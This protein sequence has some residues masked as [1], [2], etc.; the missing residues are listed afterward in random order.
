M[1]NSVWIA[2]LAAAI[3]AG[4]P[5]LFAALGEIIA[6]RAGVLNLGVEGMMLVGAVTGFMV[7]VKTASPWLGF[8]AALVAAGATAAIF[9]VLTI[10]LRANQVVTGLALTIFGTG[11]SGFLGKPYVG[12]PL[13]VSFKPVALPLLSQIPFI[14]PIFFRHDPLVYLSYILVPALWYYFYRTRPGLNLRAVGEN[15]AAADALGVN[16]FALR[17]IYVIIGGMLA[18]AGGAF[19]SLAY[20][21]SWLENMTAGRGWIAVALVIFAVWDPVKALLGSYLFGGVDALTYGLQAATK[22]AIPSFFLKMLPYILTVIVLIFATR[23]T[24]VKHVG[25]PGALSIPYDREER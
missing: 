15:P 23:Q 18:G 7:A 16:V 17:Y 10:T 6:E 19:L 25:A 20:A 3:T 2:T 14:G 11:L 24:I 21:P 9:A 1:E 13:P 8:L 12:I 4:T 5:I 22:I